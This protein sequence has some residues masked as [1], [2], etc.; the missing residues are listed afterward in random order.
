MMG[1]K[2]SA[3]ATGSGFKEIPSSEDFSLGERLSYMDRSKRGIVTHSGRGHGR[4]TL[5]GRGKRSTNQPT[6][7]EM[8]YFVRDEVKRIRS[9]QNIL[10]LQN[11]NGLITIP[12]FKTSYDVANTLARDTQFFDV[13]EITEYIDLNIKNMYPYDSVPPDKKVRLPAPIT[14]LY[15]NVYD[16]KTQ[17]TKNKTELMMLCVSNSDDGTSFDICTFQRDLSDP[18]DHS[19]SPVDVQI[20]TQLGSIDSNKGVFILKDGTINYE[21]DMWEQ[22]P[23]EK[24]ALK[25]QKIALRKVAAYLQTINKPRFVKTGK[26][27]YSQTK[28]LS[29]KKGL[30]RFI[31]DQWNMVAWNVDEPVEV[32]SYEEGRGGRQALHYRRGFYRRALP[33]W[34]GAEIIDGLWRIYVE[35]YEAGHP[36]FGVKKS[37]HLPRIKGENRR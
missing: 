5:H 31:A 27:S 34:E 33:H 18:E 20:P 11:M 10:N 16:G 21:D 8:L 15:T 35:G 6:R 36:A 9:N 37:Y 12:R 22:K 23:S 29:A 2:R 4:N 3:K 25:D 30:K 26:I 17:T 14:A 28:R 32:K 7:R 13:S 1:R 24:W 19:H